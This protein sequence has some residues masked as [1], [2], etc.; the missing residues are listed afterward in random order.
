MRA[1][2]PAPPAQTR[3]A[4]SPAG[5]RRPQPDFQ[6][7]VGLSLVLRFHDRQRPDLAGTRDVSAAVGLGVV[8]FDL[9]DPN[10]REIPWN[11]VPGKPDEVRSF[12]LLAVDE[13]DQDP[14]LLGDH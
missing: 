3:F 2:A 11:E 13:P 8:P 7:A 5:P 6:P 10:S 4:R 14:P 12:K 9:D 1:P